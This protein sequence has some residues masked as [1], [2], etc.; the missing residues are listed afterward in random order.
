LIEFDPTD[1]DVMLARQF[2][3]LLEDFK[4]ERSSENFIPNV[5]TS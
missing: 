1:P 5:Q 3:A 2:D 4:H